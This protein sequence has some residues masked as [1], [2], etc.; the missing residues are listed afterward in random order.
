VPEALRQACSLLTN[1]AGVHR[2]FRLAARVG[3]QLA[4][5]PTIGAIS[6]KTAPFLV[7][8]T[9][10]APLAMLAGVS[11]EE[12]ETVGLLATLRRTYTP[13]EAGALLALAHLRRRAA[14]KFPAADR[15]FF[16]GEAL[17]QLRGPLRSTMRAGSM[18]ERL[19]ALSWI[20][21]AGSAA[22]C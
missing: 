1:C 11:L 13:E 19:R 3:V 10:R 8:E 20:W 2:C 5:M 12:T 7:S 9:A 16:T 14:T 17:E 22:T 4:L 6:A 15:L 21:A 18:T